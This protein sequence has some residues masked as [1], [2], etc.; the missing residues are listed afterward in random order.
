MS[1]N[2]TGAIS[3]GGSTA[4]Q[5]VNLELGLSATAQISFNDARVRTL[6]GTTSGTTLVMP[7]AFYGKEL[8]TVTVGHTEIV[9]KSGSIFIYGYNTAF[10]QGNIRDGTFG[11]KGNASINSLYWS[12]VGLMQFILVGN[13]SNDGWTK[14]T[15]NGNDYTRASAGYSYDS[16]SNTTGWV[17]S[18]YTN[19]FG[20]VDGVEK[21]VVFTK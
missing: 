1:L 20:T 15:I 8:Q 9:I 12:S 5:S 14:M 19:E 4:G 2:S 7:T 11:L 10:A 18:T 21:M 3:L 6:T 16:S 17:W 13:Q